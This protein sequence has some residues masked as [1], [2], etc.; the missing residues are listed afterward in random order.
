MWALDHLCACAGALRAPGARGAADGGEGRLCSAGPAPG[1][2]CAQGRA[3]SPPA[4][5]DGAELSPQWPD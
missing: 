2:L 5:Q 1:P 3:G 4:A